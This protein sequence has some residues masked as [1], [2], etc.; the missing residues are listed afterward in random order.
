MSAVLTLPQAVDPVRELQKRFGLLQLGGD[1]RVVEKPP[2]GGS[3][4][5]VKEI[6][7][8]TTQAGQTLLSRA[9][10]TI[11]SAMPKKQA[12]EAFKSSPATEVFRDIAFDPRPTGPQTIN[13]WRGP[14]LKPVPGL[15]PVLQKYLLDGVCSG[16]QDL[17][18]YLLNFLAHMLQKPE[19]KPGVMIVLIGGQG[20]GKGT[21]LRLIQNIWRDTSFLTNQIDHV[22]GH[23]N[24]VLERQYIILL[25]EA[26]FVG[27]RGATDRLKSLITEPSISIEEKHGPVRS[28]FSCHRF[29]ATT[30][31]EHFAHIDR[32]DR[33]MLYIPLPDTHKGD[34]P[35]WNSVY[36][37]LSTELP[38]L[39]THLQQ[40]DITTFRPQERPASPALIDQKVRSLVGVPAW[41]LDVL[42]NGEF[43]R[44]PHLGLTIPTDWNSPMFISS[45]DMREAYRE[46]A[47]YK[48]PHRR[49]ITEH[50]LKQQLAKMCRSAMPARRQQGS[51]QARGIDLPS[52]QAARN[53]FEIYI[54]GPIQW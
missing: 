13:L 19:E 38:A 24:N 37:A 41:W 14:T 33:R 52:L 29:V 8:Y 16:D 7:G 12:V 6:S 54:G 25:D 40:R 43:A 18:D 42:R 39:M 36:T 48:N 3:W 9:L 26:L 47:K 15:F 21:F 23:F 50:D 4:A 44:L 30:N 2:L 35:Y 45:A 34:I 11:P 53:E 1:I 51:K 28:M 31:A 32:D 27:N 5:D 20:T 46:F 10:E 49:D 17:N 22:T